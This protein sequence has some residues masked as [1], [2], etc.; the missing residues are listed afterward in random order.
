M[1]SEDNLSGKVK[2]KRYLHDPDNPNSLSHNWVIS[3]VEDYR[4]RIWASTHGGGLNRLNRETDSFTRYSNDPHNPY[5]LRNDDLKR[6]YEDPMQQALWIGSESGGVYKCAYNQKQ[7][8]HYWHD[9]YDSNSLG[10]NTLFGIHEDNEGMIWIGT[11]IKG[12]DRFD[13]KT[14]TFT[15]FRN[16]PNDPN[17][18]HH[19]K[20]QAVFEDRDGNLW[21]GTSHGLSRFD[22]DRNK[23]ISYLH[24][25]NGEGTGDPVWIQDIKQDPFSGEQAI[26]IATTGTSLKKYYY[27]ENRFITY[28]HDPNNPYSL[29]NEYIMTIY[30]DPDKSK[31]FLWIGTEDGLNKFDLE[32]ETFSV[33]K[34]ESDNPNSMSHSSVWSIHRDKNGILWVGT[35]GGGLNRFDEQSEKFIHYTEKDGLAGN[36][37]CGILE[38]NHGNLWI[39]TMGGLSKF[40]TKKER[41]LN[42]HTGD[43]LQ[44]NEYWPFSYAKTRAG[45]MYFG[46]INGFNVF[47]PDSIKVNLKV[48]RIV[49]TDFKLFNQSVKPDLNAPINREL[50]EAEEIILESDQDFFTIEFAALD[51]TNPEKDQYAY[52]LE[53]VDRDW[54]PSDASR[55]F[56]TYTKLDPGEY[57]F[58]VKGSNNDGIWN[59]E[60]ISVKITILPPWWRSLLRRSCILYLVV[61]KLLPKI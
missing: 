13:P 5:G 24:G 60:G 37:V 9:P 51:Y 27:K 42:F 4:G 35:N 11:Q 28:R 44:S 39:S 61:A 31:R 43:G 58:R 32:R 3:I 6:I 48:P 52:L 30:R 26:W 16:D 14:N 20:V 41:F 36:I 2:F 45:L 33:Y 29:S 25:G 10:Q 17:S 57:L 59:A 23:F 1:E 15:H 38:D 47:H 46:G 49:L 34:N 8:K 40:N 12:L 18:L 53:G 7:F 54:V 22:R 19:N 21:I 55:R 56:A 50:S